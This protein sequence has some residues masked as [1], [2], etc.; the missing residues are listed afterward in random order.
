MNTYELCLFD[1]GNKTK[2]GLIDSTLFPNCEN[3]DIALERV[4]R[5]MSSQ[6]LTLSNYSFSLKKTDKVKHYDC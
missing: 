6:G 4:K 1:K 2:F 3:R 5:V